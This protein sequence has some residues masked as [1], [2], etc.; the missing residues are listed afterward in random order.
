M[1]KSEETT[2]NLNQ[3]L[4]VGTN[5]QAGKPATNPAVLITHQMVIRGLKVRTNLQGGAIPCTSV[6]M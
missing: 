6:I 3:D 2:S 1:K 4:K 5:F